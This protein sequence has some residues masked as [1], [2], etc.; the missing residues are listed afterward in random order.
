MAD[1]ALTR[2][3]GTRH[4]SWVQRHATRD[5]RSAR[6]ALVHYTN[7]V[8]PVRSSIP[9]VL[10]IQDLSLIRYPHYHPALR[11][12]GVPFMGFSAH[13]A[14][15]VIVPSE[16]T[17]RELH[18]LLRVPLSKVEIIQLAPRPHALATGRSTNVLTRFGLRSGQY[19]LSIATLEPRK[20]IGRLV[21]AFER[22]AN[23]FVGLRLVLVGGRGWRTTSIDRAIAASPVHDRI[24]LTGYV[25]DGELAA[26]LGECGLFVYVSLYEGYG[27]PIVEAMQAGAP[28]VTSAVS[29]M[30]EA[31]GGAAVLVNPRDPNAIVHGIEEGLENRAALIAAG[32]RRVAGLSWRRV[33]EETLAVYDDALR[34]S[35]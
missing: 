23:R 14:R 7:A 25:D 11:L 2:M 33:A 29:S 30:P 26:L 24:V 9:F 16:A 35:A 15:R 21:T 18:R 34:N 6:A 22:I 12:A 13:R 32:Q 31:A 4:L 28:V 3:R 20:N 10:T 17:A 8:A 5:V 1:R 27:L 19:L